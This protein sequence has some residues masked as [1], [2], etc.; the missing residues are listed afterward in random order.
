M[1][2]V[3]ILFLAVLYAGCFPQPSMNKGSS[4]GTNTI[5]Q[6]GTMVKSIVLDA[7]SRDRLSNLN[8]IGKLID[9]AKA[10]GANT[11]CIAYNIPFDTNGHYLNSAPIYGS[12]ISIHPEHL[13]PVI[14]LISQKNLNVMI[15]PMTSIY[16]PLAPGG[17][18]SVGNVADYSSPPIRPLISAI[19][20][21][22]TLHS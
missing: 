5:S 15:K 2:Q 11:I 17:P 22:T 13:I 21:L 16:N 8:V 6:S 3:L 1:K 4:L 14:R 18:T 20:L 9:L 7:W 10:S 19:S 12:D